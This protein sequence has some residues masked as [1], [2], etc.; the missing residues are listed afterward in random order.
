M[1]GMGLMTLIIQAYI[2]LSPDLVIIDNVIIFFAGLI[3]ALAISGAIAGNS[4]AFKA[5][6]PR[7]KPA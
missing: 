7:L 6:P 4:L 5:P 1:M 2:I 3:T